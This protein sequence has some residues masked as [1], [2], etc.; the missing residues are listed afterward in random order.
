MPLFRTNEKEPILAILLL[1][2]MIISQMLGANEILITLYLAFTIY[3]GIG[4]GF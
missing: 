3:V 4:V 1:R 2:Y